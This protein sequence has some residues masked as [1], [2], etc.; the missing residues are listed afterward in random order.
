MTTADQLRQ[1]LAATHRMGEDGVLAAAGAAPF[2]Y[3]D[4]A[5]HEAFL[6]GVM[7]ERTRIGSLCAVCNPLCQQSQLMRQGVISAMP[8]WNKFLVREPL[9]QA[10]K[11]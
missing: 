11:R 7:A 3:S 4:G 9:L 8:D 1:M 2:V 10:L 5:E 6:A